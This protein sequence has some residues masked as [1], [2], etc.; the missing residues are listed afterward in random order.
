M[1]DIQ[2]SRAI[3]KVKMKA[4]HISFIAEERKME[5]IANF[6]GYDIFKPNKKECQQANTPYPMYIAVINYFDESASEIDMSMS[7][8]DAPTLDEQKE[9]CKANRIY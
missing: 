2:F 1:L 8:N 3:M 6:Y 9:W 7:E 5:R 4:N